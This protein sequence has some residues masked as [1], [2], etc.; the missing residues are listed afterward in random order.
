MKTTVSKFGITVPLRANSRA[1]GPRNGFPDLRQLDI[2]VTQNL[3]IIVMFVSGEKT[4]QI[5]H[6]ANQFC[7]LLLKKTAECSEN[8]KN[9]F[10]AFLQSGCSF[11]S[12]SKS[13][14]ALTSLLRMRKSWR[15]ASPKLSA[16]SILE[17]VIFSFSLIKVTFLI[18][19]KVQKQNVRSNSSCLTCEC[20]TLRS[21]RCEEVGCS[22]GEQQPSVSQL[23]EDGN[24]SP[25]EHAYGR[26]STC[27]LRALFFA[28]P[29]A[30]VTGI[31]T[32]E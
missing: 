24:G 12:P 21:F 7:R 14:L 28:D 23:H 4:P 31:S 30:T 29:N 3:L 18:L 16:A 2:G 17:T 27:C 32:R 20:Q 26:G 13:G 22:A 15:K 6:I 9:A 10:L 11:Q 19:S 5:Q 25:P 1:R 8:L